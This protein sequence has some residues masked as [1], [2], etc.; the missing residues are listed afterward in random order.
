M[1]STLAGILLLQYHLSLVG[2]VSLPGTQPLELTVAPAPT[3]NCGCHDAFDPVGF[4]E[5][6]QSYRATAMALSGR[7]PLFRAALAV[8]HQD[9]PELSDLCIRCH[10]PVGWLSGRSTPGDGGAL[11]P[12]DVDS[13]VACDI[14]HRMIPTD[15]PLIGSGQY[16]LA[17]TSTK[18]ARRG[19]GDL[20]PHPVEASDF[21]ASSEMCGRCH[22]LFNPAERAHDA[23]GADLGTVYYEQRT[24]EEWADSAVADR[25]TCVDCHM[26]TAHGAAARNGAEYE[27]LSVHSF[28]G[29]NLFVMNAAR[30]LDPTL[31]ISR[32]IP[33]VTAW[34]EASLRSAAA[35][36]IREIAEGA[37]EVE[38]DAPFALSVRLTNLTGHK[39]PT[40]YPE[41]RRVYLEVSLQM[42][43]G[44]GTGGGGEAEGDGPIILSGAWDERTGDLVYD[45]QLRTYET[46]HGAYAEGIGGQRTHHLLL[47]NQILTDTRIPPEGFRPRALD[48]MP[49]GRDYGASA[50]YRNYDDVTY[51]FRAPAVASVRTATITVRAMYQSVDGQTVRFLVEEAMGTEA[52]DD[53]DLVWRSIGPMPP[54]EMAVATAVLTVKPGS[55]S[56]GPDAGPSDGAVD[57]DGAQSATLDDSGGCGCAATAGGGVRG[58]S[59]VRGPPGSGPG[60][61]LFLV[62]FGALGLR[63]ASRRGGLRR[64]RAAAFVASGR[65][66]AR[67]S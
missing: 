58:A 21:I 66:S 32:E 36:E 13:G 56:G 54:T 6:G 12:E 3:A 42:D 14:C 7:D 38:G 9:H 31:P 16:T 34:I 49:S 2:E 52:G 35:L 33:V 61:L 24:Y 29:G 44:A 39:L 30:V 46:E 65:G 47:M 59:S 17:P 18:R 22:S 1:N 28:V 20:A 41:G 4:N 5:P 8:S 63:C 15:P 48:M 57:V 60:I 67:A 37:D 64:R 19:R 27:D 50:P 45:D 51:R 62:F 23:A 43:G 40:G 55:S 25:A 53:L 11:T 26:M 10:M